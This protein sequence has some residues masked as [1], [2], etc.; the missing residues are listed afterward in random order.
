MGSHS[1]AVA[2][3]GAREVVI[4]AVE[5]SKRAEGRGGGEAAM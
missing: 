5:R 3:V 2:V 1:S 4:E